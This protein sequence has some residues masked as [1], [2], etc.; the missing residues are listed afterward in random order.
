MAPRELKKLSLR[1][2]GC[3]LNQYETEKMAADLMPYGFRRSEPGEEAD[4]CI[5]N[6]CTVT[7][8]ADADDRYLVK[9]AA[10]EHPKAKV[11]VVG[12]Y[13][14]KDPDF[15]KGLERVD[16]VVLNRDKDRIA[17]ILSE[18]FPDLFADPPD[19]GCATGVRFEQYNRAWVKVSDGCNQR[20]AFCILPSVRG[21]LRNRAA[22]LIVDEINSLVAD[23]FQEIALTGLH[24][25]LYRDRDLK[26]PI[27][28]L[29]ELCRLILRETEIARIRL[30]SIEPQTVDDDL[31]KVYADA[32]GRICRHL[33]MPLQSGSDGIL[34]LMRR[35]YTREQYITCA[36]AVRAVRPDTIIGADIIVGFP[37]ETDED[38]QASRRMA[39]MGLVDYWHIFSYSDRPGT[40]ASE[41]D[42]KVSPDV[43]KERRDILRII[44]EE[45]RRRAYRRQIGQTLNVIAERKP[46]N[47]HRFLGVADNYVRVQLPESYAGGRGIVPVLVTSAHDDYVAGDLLV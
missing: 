17:E 13:V 34:K 45:W 37:G 4:L 15:V 5:I 35:P 44:S 11:V 16:A 3:R 46:T 38:F 2:V 27:R 25:G 28:N 31:L 14:D 9:R 40:R 1:T 7:H 12:C 36:A 47:G 32:N 21:E 23:G 41:Y 19:H 24:L 8:R 42:H 43:I 33:H 26:S 10:R 22:G 6:T 39:E 20:C 18:R 30:S 29:A